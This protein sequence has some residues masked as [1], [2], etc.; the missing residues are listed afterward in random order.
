MRLK[1][2]VVGPWNLSS[3]TV[4][5]FLLFQPLPLGLRT[6]DLT[7]TA[8]LGVLIL[9]INQKIRTGRSGLFMI[10]LATTTLGTLYS[11]FEGET[12]S[13]F[14]FFRGMIFPMLMLWLIQANISF[15]LF[16]ELDRILPVIIF[17]SVA[18]A[19]LYFMFGSGL[20]N[21]TLDI[22]YEDAVYKRFFIYPTYFFLIL[23]VDAVARSSPTQ[24][25]YSLLLAASGSK[26]I[27][28]SFMIVYFFFFVKNFSYKK[29][30]IKIQHYQDN[31]E[32]QSH[33]GCSSCP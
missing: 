29:I 2:N 23:F 22:P 31:E 11:A 33:R 4:A 13:L 24:L 7:I 16:K 26:A 14:Q 27:Y 1:L 17:G 19:F 15:K 12:F 5:L 3:T 30:F 8:L 25:V 28:L 9:F 6:S 20:Y 21:S 32:M 18:S 10:L